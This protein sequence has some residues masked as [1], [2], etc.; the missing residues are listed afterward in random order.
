MLPSVSEGCPNLPQRD[1]RD[2]LM[3]FMRAMLSHPHCRR[4]ANARK[5][6]RKAVHRVRMMTFAG[7]WCL[8]CFSTL[9]AIRLWINVATISRLHENALF[10][11]SPA[12]T[13]EQ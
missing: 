5:L 4:E 11:D 3:R 6:P 8:R 13:A 9:T 12:P 2:T 1:I 7:A 10:I